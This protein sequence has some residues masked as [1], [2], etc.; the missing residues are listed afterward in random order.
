M[1]SHVNGM[2]RLRNLQESRSQ[3]SRLCGRTFLEVLW[4]QNHCRGQERYDETD[5]PPRTRSVQYST[6][7]RDFD[8]VGDDDDDDDAWNGQNIEAL[9]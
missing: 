7:L 9:L 6:Q 2:L 3:E 4:L 8:A 5:I 1:R